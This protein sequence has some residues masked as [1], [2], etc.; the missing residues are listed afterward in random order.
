[1]THEKDENK[2]NLDRRFPLIEGLYILVPLTTPQHDR[3]YLMYLEIKTQK[4][5]LKI[6]FFLAAVD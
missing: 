2:N 1:M 4:F 3:N 5:L 6:M